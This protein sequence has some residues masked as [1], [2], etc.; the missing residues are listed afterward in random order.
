[1]SVFHDDVEIEDLEYE[2]EEETYKYP[3]PCDDRFVIT[4]E[5]LSHG[6]QKEETCLESQNQTEA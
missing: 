1:M 6:F 4:K 3:C 5:E 2:D